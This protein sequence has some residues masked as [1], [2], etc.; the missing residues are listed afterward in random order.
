MPSRDA[1]GWS[2]RFLM[3]AAQ[4]NDYTGVRTLVRRLPAAD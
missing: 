1:L 4:V 3:T 2:D